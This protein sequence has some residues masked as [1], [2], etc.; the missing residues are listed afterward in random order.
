MA[1]ALLLK[2]GFWMTN[3][4]AEL[5]LAFEGSAL[6]QDGHWLPALLSRGAPQNWHIFSEVI[7]S[8]IFE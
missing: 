1:S 3:V 2:T 8:P 5:L 6:P 7:F 4:A